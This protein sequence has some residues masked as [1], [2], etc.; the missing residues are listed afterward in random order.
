M[1]Q[2]TLGDGSLALSFKYEPFGKLTNPGSGYNF[3]FPGQYYDDET[4]MHYNYHRDYDASLG[5]YIQSDPIGLRGGWNMYAYVGGNPVMHMDW[6]GLSEQDVNAMLDIARRY[7][8]GLPVPSCIRYKKMVDNQ[9]GGY[10][11]WSDNLALNENYKN[12]TLNCEEILE[13]YEAILHESVHRDESILGATWDYYFNNEEFQEK[14][15][16]HNQRTD[17]T[18]ERGRGAIWAGISEVLEYCELCDEQRK[19]KYNRSAECVGPLKGWF[20]YW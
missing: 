16:K 14:R 7:T 11:P 18:Y 6:R 17:E 15:R 10:Y 19:R 4:G 5:R 3:R 8:D 12:K 20:G 1:T 9:G 13:L 2:V